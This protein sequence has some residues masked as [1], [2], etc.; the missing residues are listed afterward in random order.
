MVTKFALFAAI[1]FGCAFASASQLPDYPFI[2][3]SGSAS[4]YVM[5]DKGTI[6]F[7]IVAVN[8]DPA[9]AR[10]IVEGRVA[11]VRALMEAQG[12]QAVDV[13]VRDVRQEQPKS[14]G[15][16]AGSLYEVR[17][18]VHLNVSNLSRWTAIAGALLGK[19]N[20]AAFATAFDSS[21]RDRIEEELMAQAIRDAQRRGAAIAAGFGRKLGAVSAVSPGALKNLGKA[22][23]LVNADPIYRREN[24]AQQVDNRDILNVSAFP[25]AQSVDVIYR[26]K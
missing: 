22:M 24:R 25:L 1:T 15:G 8:A 11:E 4:T 23:G 19:P 18:V 13:E 6:D 16:T 17:C 26:F 21:N 10:E 3:A 5:P 14:D 2:H 7:E 20:L 12:M 9:A